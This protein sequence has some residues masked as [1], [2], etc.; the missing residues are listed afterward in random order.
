MGKMQLNMNEYHYSLEGD[1]SV[2]SIRTLVGM[3][4]VGEI[5]VVH[6]SHDG[7]HCVDLYQTKDGML[8]LQGTYED[9]SDELFM[10][11]YTATFACLRM[12]GDIPE[13]MIDAFVETAMDLDRDE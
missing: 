7:K 1:V 8:T 2:D 9:D 5:T 13:G 12:E 6:W 3:E 11:V 4:Y 10:T